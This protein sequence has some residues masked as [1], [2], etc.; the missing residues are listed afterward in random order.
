MS[1]ELPERDLESPQCVGS[2]AVVRCGAVLRVE[3]WPEKII[4]CVLNAAVGPT[5]RRDIDVINKEQSI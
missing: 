3:Y 5:V 4:V 1:I 2:L